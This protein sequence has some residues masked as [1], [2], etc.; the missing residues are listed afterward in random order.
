MARTKGIPLLT[1]F[2]DLL[3][4]SGLFTLQCEQVSAE[5]QTGFAQSSDI[6]LLLCTSGTT[7]K[8]KRVPLAHANLCSSVQN[9]RT[10]LQ[11]T[12]HDRCLNV[13]PL[14]HIHGLVA[15]LL[16]S[17]ASGASVVCSPGFHAL[18]FFKWMKIFLPTWYTAVPSIHQAILARADLNQ[19]IIKACPLRFIRSS[20]SPLPPQVIEGL[21]NVFHAPVIEAYGMTEA[22][23]Q[24]SSNPLPPSPR[25][26][27]S[28][29]RAAG[30]AVAIM[31]EKGILQ[32]SEAIGEV[33]ICGANV[34]QGYEDDALANQNAFS[35]G[36]FRTGDQGYLDADHYL[37]LTGR[38]KEIINRGGEKISP[39]EVDEVLMNHPAVAQA[40]AFAVPDP[41]LGEEVG[42]AIVLHD[43]ISA[44]KKELREFAAS[45]L[46]AFKT[47]KYITFLDEIPTGPTGKPQRVSLAQS[48]GLEISKQMQIGLTRIWSL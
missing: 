38:I 21:E 17:L 26:I 6:A 40:I 37:F 7:S 2:P 4:E 5:L 1:L 42:A 46:A 47:P 12:D 16:T 24:I 8:P 32:P 28:V 3:R 20:S 10:V 43:G 45:R 22:S 30:P 25:K 39:R 9:I 11:L 18:E 23:H 13:M 36:W 29:G 14:F 48:L 44:T 35:S 19:E 34:T 27:G 15:A 41:Q 33:V 31:N